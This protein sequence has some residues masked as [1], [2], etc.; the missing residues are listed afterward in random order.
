MSLK[1]ISLAL[2]SGIAAFLIVGVAVTE[3]TQPWIEF[4]LFLGIP[5]GIATGAFTAAGVYLGLADDSPAGR[6][7]IAGA[8]AAFGAGFIVA[9]VV[10]GWVVNT[11]VTTAIVISVIVALAVGAVAYIR[12][13]KEVAATIGDEGETPSRTN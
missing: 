3:F 12:S 5:A 8:F 7:R 1:S 9:L 6:R 4:S 11:G 10:F 2:L 13:P